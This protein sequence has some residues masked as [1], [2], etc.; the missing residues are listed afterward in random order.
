[1][2]VDE[3]PFISEDVHEGDVMVMVDMNG[4]FHHRVQ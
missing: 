1:M 2:D 3:N 4:V